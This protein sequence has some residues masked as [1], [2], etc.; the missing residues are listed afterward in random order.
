M[1]NYDVKIMNIRIN[2]LKKLARD[3]RMVNYNNLF[4]KTGNPTIGNYD[5]LKRFGTLHNLLIDLLNEK[6]S[7]SKEAKKQNEMRKK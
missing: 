2:F 1:L 6:I 7:I 3:K 4:F 5:F